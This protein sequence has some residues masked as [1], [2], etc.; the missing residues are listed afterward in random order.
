[1]GEGLN[2]REQGG[3]LTTLTLEVRP[4]GNTPEQRCV[5][6][7]SL[8]D[9][10]M[11]R[12][13]DRGNLQRAWKRVKS[14][15]GAPGIDGL[16]IEEFAAYAR[17]HWSEIRQA[18]N[19]GSYRPQPV[20]RVTIPKPDGGERH[21]G[22]PTVTDRVIQQAIAQVLNPIFDPGFSESSFGF[23]EGRGAHGALKQVKR[24]V[25]EGRRIAVDLA[26]V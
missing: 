23:R 15:K 2:M 6:K 10:L 4:S 22:I 20:K 17:N 26:R 5:T 16:P 9:N 21:L 1:M 25:Q 13:L 19:D 8:H 12:V 7:P 24:Y 18:L 3:A 14:N 11:E